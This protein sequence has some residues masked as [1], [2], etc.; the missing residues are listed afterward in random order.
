MV[1]NARGTYMFPI[2]NRDKYKAYIK[3]TPIIKNGPTYHNR[4]NIA[5]TEAQSSSDLNSSSPSIAREGSIERAAKNFLENAWSQF[6]NSAIS[7]STERR[8]NESVALYMP[9]PVTIQDGV[10]IE[11]ASLGILGEGAS[12]SM[13]AGSGIGAAVGAALGDGMGSLIETLKGNLT[14]D[15]ASLGASRLAA[16]LPGP[17]A[18]AVRGSLRVTPNP[19]TRMMFRSVNIREFSFDFKMVPTSEREQYEIKNIVTFFRSNLYP[20]VIKLEGTG[21]NSIDAG[22]KFP[23]LFEIKLMYDGKDLSKD[24]PNLSFKHMY[25]KAFTASYNS[26]GGFYKDGE[27]NEVSIQVSFAEEFTLNKS[28][29]LVGN[30]HKTSKSADEAIDQHYERNGLIAQANDGVT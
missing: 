3:F 2:E 13:D 17:G 21:G 4:V 16:G 11:Q 24:K 30:S 5:Q 7:A 6:G 26:T 1:N 23:N 8:G 15:A 19:N 27:F 12:R 29:A 18:D 20:D 22:Y 9:T 14:G 28:D 25:L 10:S